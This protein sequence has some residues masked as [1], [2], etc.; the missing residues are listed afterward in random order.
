MERPHISEAQ[1]AHPVP[2]C[3]IPHRTVPYRTVP[4]LAAPSRTALTRPPAHQPRTR[5]AWEQRSHG[6]Q[7]HNHPTHGPHLAHPAQHSLPT[8][9]H[10]PSSNITR[11]PLSLQSTGSSL[12]IPSVVLHLRHLPDHSLPPL[13]CPRLP[14]RPISPSQPSLCPILLPRRPRPL[15]LSQ[16][17][18]MPPLCIRC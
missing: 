14:T 12:L 3:A 2:P 9:H 13:F 15:P 1:T 5:T 8:R 10:P 7:P 6:P 16:R 17:T 4:C 18:T 11:Q